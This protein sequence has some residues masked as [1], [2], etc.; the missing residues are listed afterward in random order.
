M[1]TLRQVSGKECLKIL[2]NKFGF[3][4]VRQRGS[5]IVLRKDT[6]TGAVG[7]VVAVHENLKIKTL[8]NILKLAKVSEEDF[9]KYL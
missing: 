8:K 7:T 5:H 9:A 6:P 2:C 4:T 1:P 3:R